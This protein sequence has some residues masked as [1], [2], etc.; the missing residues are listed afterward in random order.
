MRQERGWKL[1]VM[2][3]RMLFKPPRGESIGQERLA[4]RFTRFNNGHWIDLIRSSREC[5]QEFA[6]VSRRARRRNQ[7]GDFERRTERA[8]RLAQLGELSS[9][10]Q[11]LEGSDLGIGTRWRHFRPGQVYPAILFLMTLLVT[12]LPGRPNWMRRVLVR[13]SDL[14]AEERTSTCT[15][16]GRLEAGQDDRIAETQRWHSRNC[17]RRHHPPFGLTYDGPANGSC[18]GEGNRSPPIRP[19]RM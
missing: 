18:S 6:R 15:G 8:H 16:S 9:A 3:P 17:R 12:C 13:T 7:D 11:A 10:R 4:Q 1:L 2:L 5:D 14:R 19:C